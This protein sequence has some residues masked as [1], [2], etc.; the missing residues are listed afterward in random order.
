VHKPGHISQ[1]ELQINDLEKVTDKHQNKSNLHDLKERLTKE[2]NSQ[3]FNLEPEQVTPEVT[4]KHYETSSKKVKFCCNMN[5]IPANSNDATTGHKLQGMSKNIIIVSSWPTAGLSK[6]FKN[7]EY[8]VLSRVRTLLGLY[9][10]E[11][12]DMD[13]LFNPSP[14]LRSYIGKA[15][16]NE[17]QILEERQIA[18]SQI[19]WT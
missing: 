16:K 11:P 5:Q 6:V 13:K 8:D 14:E 2:M 9:L 17:K 15:R 12:I 1:L 18:I 3:K 10:I 4:V 7:W 19:T